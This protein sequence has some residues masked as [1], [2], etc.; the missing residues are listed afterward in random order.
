M[1]RQ[2]RCPLLVW[3]V[4]ILLLMPL[5][6][7][8]A[9]DEPATIALGAVSEVAAKN[10]NSI[11]NNRSAVQCHSKLRESIAVSTDP[12]PLWQKIYPNTTTPSVLQALPR[13]FA[14]RKVFVYDLPDSFHSMLIDEVEQQLNPA[15]GSSHSSCSWG[16][17][18][19]EEHQRNG[20]YSTK[21]QGAAEVPILAKL[22]LLPRTSDPAEASL[23]VVP[24]LGWTSIVHAGKWMSSHESES[25]VEQLLTLLPHFHGDM[26]RRHVFLA[27]IDSPNIGKALTDN[28]AAK[29]GIVLTIGP[30]N[31]AHPG[32]ILV[33]SLD[34]LFG[35]SPPFN[36]H[37]QLKVFMLIGGFGHIP[38]RRAWMDNFSPPTVKD[39]RYEAHK[40]GGRSD[41]RMLPAQ[42][43]AKYADA[44]Y[45]P[46][47]P[48]D[49]THGHRFF[50]MLAA[51]CVPIVVPHQNSVHPGSNETC[52]SYYYNTHYKHMAY[53]CIELALPFVS[54]VDWRQVVLEVDPAVLLG[55]GMAAVVGSMDPAETAHRRQQVYALRDLVRYDW[56]GRSYD[57]FSALLHEVCVYQQW[58]DV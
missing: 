16:R 54:L 55:K 21:R 32:S 41:L 43:S 51:G 53:T 2:P 11:S 50:D 34:P 35:F 18:P 20:I 13:C 23:F 28:V 12:H 33:P 40:M 8:A 38:I 46:F 56:T 24:Y 57:A 47:P 25:R 19:C 4:A 6:V 39:S 14:G 1:T 27:T 10:S 31:P 37:P 15:M 45:C 3:A 17:E 52:L 26:V 58:C 22:L 44:E 5:L 36:P 30:R 7:A 48:G 29:G 42:V 49:F 9:A